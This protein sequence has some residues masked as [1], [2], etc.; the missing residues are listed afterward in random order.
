MWYEISVII[1]LLVIVID[2]VEYNSGSSR[3]SNFKIG[4]AQSLRPIWNYKHN[5]I[6]PWIVRHEVQLLINR[7]YNKIWN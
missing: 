4:R 2:R 7:N 6:I 3:A 5:I 1:L